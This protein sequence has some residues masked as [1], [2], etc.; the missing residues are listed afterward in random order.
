MFYVSLQVIGEHC[1]KNILIV[2]VGEI[3]VSFN[4]YIKEK[5]KLPKKNT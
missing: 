2:E 5:L 4:R 1:G 3:V